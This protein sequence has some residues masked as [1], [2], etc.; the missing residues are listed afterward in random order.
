LLREAGDVRTSQQLGQ[1]LMQRLAT[2]DG[3]QA[4]T[5]SLRAISN[6]GFVPALELVKPRLDDAREA[7]RADAL[8]AIRLMDVPEVDGLI[9]ARLT[10][11]PSVK[12]Q[13]AALSAIKPRKPT[14]ALAQ[15]LSGAARATDAHI[16][17]R[18]T[19]LAAAWLERRPE[20]RRT[21][22]RVA[23]Q[24]G[25]EKIRRLAATALRG[26]GKTTAARF[27]P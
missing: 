26:G 4:I 9:A 11:D 13:T 16:R 27:A 1:L 21:L 7:V 5:R 19:E 24:D 10:V 14:A 2:A 3:E 15:A 22:E 18:A 25:E 8:E 12:V 23:R 17:Y 6:S 20:L